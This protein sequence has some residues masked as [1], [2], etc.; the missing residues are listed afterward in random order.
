MSNIRR[1]YVTLDIILI[2]ANFR[3]HQTSMGYKNGSVIDPC[4]LVGMW[5]L[6]CGQ[7]KVIDHPLGDDVRCNV[8][9]DNQVTSST[10]A[11][12]SRKMVVRCQSSASSSLVVRSCI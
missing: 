3:G 1:D 8:G 11:I 7:L 2:A 9:I 4:N 10:L 6:L 5:M 12:Y